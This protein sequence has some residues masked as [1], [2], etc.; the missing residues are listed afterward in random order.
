MY[1][2]GKIAEQLNPCKSVAEKIRKELNN[3]PLFRLIK[4]T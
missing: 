2:F 1:P 3:D 4:G